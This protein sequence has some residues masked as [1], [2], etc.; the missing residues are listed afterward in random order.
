MGNPYELRT[1]G[2]MVLRLGVWTMITATA[3]RAVLSD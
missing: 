2:A 1:L 3:H